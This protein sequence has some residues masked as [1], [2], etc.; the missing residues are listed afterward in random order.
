MEGNDNDGNTSNYYM[1]DIGVIYVQP[2]MRN[3]C[4]HPFLPVMVTGMKIS[5]TTNHITYMLCTQYGDI[6]GAFPREV[7]RYEEHISPK[8]VLIN[9]RTEETQ[10]RKLTV[11]E[12]SAKHNILGGKAFYRCKKD[13]ALVRKCSCVALGKLCRDKCHGK[14]GHKV[15]CSNCITLED[16][17]H[18]YSIRKRNRTQDNS[19]ELA[20]RREIFRRESKSIVK[21]NKLYVYLV[22]QLNKCSKLNHIKNKII[23]VKVKY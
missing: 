12:A 14:D 13:C 7:I 9:P 19:K 6:C 15:N 23:N 20:R 22:M 4:D 2:K 16:K 18:N 11:E 3:S 21:K 8:I 5:G 1:G 17:S 10:G